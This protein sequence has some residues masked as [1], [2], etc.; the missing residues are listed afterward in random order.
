MEE[1]AQEHV[2]IIGDLAREYQ[3]KFKELNDFIKSGEKDRI[4]G[5]LRNQAEI[6]TDRFRGAQMFLLNNPIL[7]GKESDDKVLLAVTALCRCF[8][9]MRI[10]FQVLLE[11]SEQDQ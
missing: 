7:T 4:P 2:R 5:Y 9:E 11:Y 3:Q 10:L 8:D 6:T 1:G